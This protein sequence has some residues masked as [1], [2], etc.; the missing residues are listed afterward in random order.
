MKFNGVEENF[1][2]IFWILNL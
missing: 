2:I 1:L